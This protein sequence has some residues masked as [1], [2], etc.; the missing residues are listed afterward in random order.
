MGLFSRNKFFHYDLYLDGSWHSFDELATPFFGACKK[1]GF[2]LTAE[3]SGGN[4]GVYNARFDN[5]CVLTLTMMDSGASLGITQQ[6]SRDTLSN[7][8]NF[9]EGVKSIYADFLN[10]LSM[11]YDFGFS[12]DVTDTNGKVLVG[13]WEIIPRKKYI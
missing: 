5:G 11:N 1:Y 8:P 10:I 9:R 3:P 13:N 12:A 6:F 7:E 2:N 4:Y